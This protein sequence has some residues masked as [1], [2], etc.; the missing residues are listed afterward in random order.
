MPLFRYDL[1]LF[2]SCRTTAA[3]GWGHTSSGRTR[4]ASAAW[5]AP[6]RRRFIACQHLPVCEPNTASTPA[7]T[8]H[9]P[10]PASGAGLKQLTHNHF[11][12]ETGPVHG[13]TLSAKPPQK[14]AFS[15]E[16][17]PANRM[18]GNDLGATNCLPVPYKPDMLHL[19]S[20]SNPV[21]KLGCCLTLCCARPKLE[22]NWATNVGHMNQLLSEIWLAQGTWVDPSR[23][24]DGGRCASK[25]PDDP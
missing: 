23:D 12:W 18:L 6:P 11:E 15:P 19:I 25:I 20:A 14:N 21:S 7:C 9:P 24:A 2:D 5:S 4:I 10:S 13:Q 16:A 1:K 8:G 22:S 3:D 17:I